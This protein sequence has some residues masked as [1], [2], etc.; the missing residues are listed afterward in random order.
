MHN[1]KHLRHACRLQLTGCHD[2][3][4]AEVQDI[5]LYGYH[6][7]TYYYCCIIIIISY[8]TYVIKVA[9]RLATGRLLNV[10]ICAELNRTTDHFQHAS[11]VIKPLQLACPAFV[12]H[13]GAN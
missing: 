4:T 7:Y 12:T 2:L 6:Y 8:I 9:G 10:N 1:G 3:A 13:K 5:V 11:W